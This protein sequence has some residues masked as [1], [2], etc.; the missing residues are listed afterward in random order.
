ML[1]FED[2]LMNHQMTFSLKAKHA[3]Q[4]GSEESRNSVG[5]VGGNTHLLH[6]R[7]AFVLG[8]LQLQRQDEF[9]WEL[10][11]TIQ[12]FLSLDSAGD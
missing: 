6:T 8:T 2:E 11:E 12:S 9:S 7:G 10:L 1:T 4:G 5:I 3:L